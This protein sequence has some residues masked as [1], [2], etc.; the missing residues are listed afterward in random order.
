YLML[1]VKSK[2]VIC[3][4]LITMIMLA[5]LLIYTYLLRKLKMICMFIL[6]VA[7][8]LYLFLTDA[9]GISVNKMEKL[10]MFS[11]LQ[12]VE[13]LLETFVSGIANHPLSIII[14]VAVI[15]LGVALNLF[16]L[17]QTA[18]EEKEDEGVTEAS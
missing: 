1:I 13:K 2:L 10:Q 11:P 14:L 9:I 17:H 16:V 4:G 3:V 7:L 15:L 5:M 12:Y 8:S 6:L 18:R